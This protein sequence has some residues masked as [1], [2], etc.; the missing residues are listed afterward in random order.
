M[1]AFRLRFEDAGCP[2]LSMDTKKKELIGNSWNPVEHRLCSFI[3][4]EWAGHPL[5]SLDAMMKYIRGTTTKSGLQVSALL[6]DREYAKGK[7]GA[8][9][10]VQNHSPIEP[11]RTSRLELFHSFEMTFSKCQFIFAQPL[12]QALAGVHSMKN[13]LGEGVVP[14]SERFREQASSH[15]DSVANHSQ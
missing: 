6:N 11:H 9:S 8:P 12:R 14:G 13:P 7:K 5:R 15:S 10:S 2:I 3:T 4:K 1:K